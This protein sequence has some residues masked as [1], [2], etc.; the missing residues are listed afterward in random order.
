MTRQAVERRL[1]LLMTGHTE[2]HRQ[3]YVTLSDGLLGDV[4][5]TG[6]AVDLG[7]DV[8]CVVEAHVRRAR[9]AVH[10]LPLEIQA[11]CLQLGDLDDARRVARERSVARH[12]RPDA[13]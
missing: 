10:S 7:A 1:V 11:R 12:A 6:G 9:V 2:A 5:V 3:V 13:G 8:G 4:P